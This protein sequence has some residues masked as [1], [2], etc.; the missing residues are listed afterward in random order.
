MHKKD[1]SPARL[2]GS[3][4]QFSSVEVE[5]KQSQL[6]VLCVQLVLDLDDLPLQCFTLFLE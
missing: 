4:R 2:K 3:I 5:S 1:G 6:L